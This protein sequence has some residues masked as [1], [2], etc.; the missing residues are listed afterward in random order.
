MFLTF[1]HKYVTVVPLVSVCF[2]HKMFHPAY[3][4]KLN[5]CGRQIDRNCAI[6]VFTVYKRYYFLDRRITVKTTFKSSFTTTAT[7][8]VPTTTVQYSATSLTSDQTSTV[9]KDIS[10][11]QLGEPVAQAFALYG[12]GSVLVRFLHTK[13]FG[14]IQLSHSSNLILLLVIS[15]CFGSSKLLPFQ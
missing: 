7:T 10:T 11:P 3:D 12:V 1:T 6:L 4:S 15:S 5:F 14:S 8:T 2:V 9:Y 13:L